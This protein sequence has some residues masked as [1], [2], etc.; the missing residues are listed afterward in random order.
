MLNLQ[1]SGLP[2]DINASNNPSLAMAMGTNPSL[3]M[4]TIKKNNTKITTGTNTKINT[5]TIAD[6]KELSAEY[7]IHYLRLRFENDSQKDLKQ[8]LKAAMYS[9]FRKDRVFKVLE[10]K[11]NANASIKDISKILGSTE[12]KSGLVDEILDTYMSVDSSLGQNLLRHL[13]FFPLPSARGRFIKEFM[14]S[15]HKADMIPAMFYN[16]EDLD[17]VAEYL[18]TKTQ[19]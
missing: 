13:I 9:S 2:E 7:F 8:L 6:F 3:A 16:A 5:V 4:G 10:D 11:L 1:K 18:K 19:S 14:A 15:G 12:T 17:C